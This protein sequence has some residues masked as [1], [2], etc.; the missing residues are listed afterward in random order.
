[1]EKQFNISKEILLELDLIVSMFKVCKNPKL[2]SDVM[3]A[4][5]KVD[6]YLES[7]EEEVN[8]S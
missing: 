1:M 6:K 8:E 4:I 5:E 3:M 7:M 2:D